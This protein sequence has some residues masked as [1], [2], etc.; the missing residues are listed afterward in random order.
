[1]KKIMLFL[2]C[3]QLLSCHKK[4]LTEVVE[5]PLPTKEEKI[6]I[7]DP[8]DVK[9]VDGAFEVQ[10][11]GFNYS[12]LEPTIDALTMETHYAKHYLNYTNN[13]NANLAGTE[14]QNSSIEDILKNLDLNNTD[15]RNNAGGYYNHTLYFSNLNSKTSIPQDNLANAINKDFGSFENLKTQLT[16]AAATQFGSGW[17]WLIVDKMGGLQVG[18][19]A[20]QDNPLMPKQVLSGIP[21]LAIDVWE[22]AYYLKYLNQRQK[23][24]TAL[25]NIIDWKKVGEK[26]E[27]AQK[28]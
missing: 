17:A 18:S 6:E 3:L 25:F 11:L 26:Y 20:N 19:T 1:M 8:N 23:Y 21:I 9:A 4:K 24:I 10:K 16:T 2:V 5:V 14:L 7:G 12:A 15:L 13:L 28:K 22:H 27:D